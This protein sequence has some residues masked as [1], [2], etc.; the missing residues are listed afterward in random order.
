MIE[1]LLWIRK[2]LELSSFFIYSHTQQ[3]IN[4]IAK[5][6]SIVNKL[7]LKKKKRKKD[8]K[9]RNIEKVES[10]DQD[11]KDKISLSEKKKKKK[12]N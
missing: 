9:R 8:K 10:E 11:I 5:L 12:D 1:Y 2:S 3:L 4:S 6:N 7:T